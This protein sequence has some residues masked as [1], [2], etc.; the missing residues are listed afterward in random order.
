MIAVALEP[1]TRISENT[2]K[3]YINTLV[4]NF[5]YTANEGR[6]IQATNCCIKL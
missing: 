2:E 3:I 4:P 1:T 6:K 5:E